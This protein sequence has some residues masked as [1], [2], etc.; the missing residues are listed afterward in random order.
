VRSLRELQEAFA[1]ALEGPPEALAAGL[2]VYRDSIAANYRRALGASFPVVRELVG[3]VFFDAA[4]E[5]FAAACPP[6]SGDLNV[7]GDGF[8]DFL[9]GYAAAPLAHVPDVARL[10]WAMDEALRAADAAVTPHEVLASLVPLDAERVARS[11]VLLHPSCRLLRSRY[12]LLQVWK[13][14]QPGYAGSDRVELDGTHGER[15]LVRREGGRASIERL[16]EGEH[17]W[18]CALAEGAAF[19]LAVDRAVWADPGFDLGAALR[20]RVA[21]A[22][23]AGIATAL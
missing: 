8:A 11:R 15:L 7:F 9:A 17:E 14:H 23:L 13:M 21:D 6:Q 22:T 18:L 10:E 1:R 16:G 20:A 3:E 2:A 19:A 12:P 5:A 4:V